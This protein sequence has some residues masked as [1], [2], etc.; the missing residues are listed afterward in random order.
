MTVEQ[1]TK[2]I[3]TIFNPKIDFVKVR[4]VKSPN[5]ATAND[6]GTDL[7]VPNY[8]KQFLED[9]IKKN[10]DRNLHYNLDDNNVL[11]ILIMPQER[12]LIPSGVKVNIHNKWSYLKVDNKSGIANG[13]GLL[14]GSDIVDADYRG[15]MHL[16]VINTS[17]T[18]Q[19]IVTGM[20]LVQVIH[21]LKLDTAWNEISKA[22]FD[23]LP[24]TERMDGGFSSTGLF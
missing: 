11:H 10:P 15:E 3:E 24:P 5:R 8:D 22:D 1:L 4:D 16:S 19:E 12:I 17:D 6:A 9:L 18:P 7:F 13:R 23:N 20:K 21:S 2:T 14:V